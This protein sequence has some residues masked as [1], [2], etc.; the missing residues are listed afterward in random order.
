M[1]KVFFIITFSLIFFSCSQEKELNENNRYQ[2]VMS[3]E[4][5]VTFV[6]LI[7]TKTGTVW[8]NNKSG[9]S[10]WVNMGTPPLEAK[11]NGSKTKEINLR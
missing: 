3:S 6:Y 9:I 7:D 1:N 8:R 2:L 11:T 10:F 5:D 4:A